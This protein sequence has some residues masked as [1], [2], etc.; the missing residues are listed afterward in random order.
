MDRNAARVVRDL[1]DIRHVH[2]RESDESR[3]ATFATLFQL[4][5]AWHSSLL[6]LRQAGYDKLCRL[7]IERYP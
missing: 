2:P 5:G 7:A 1:S 3:H 4:S 6:S